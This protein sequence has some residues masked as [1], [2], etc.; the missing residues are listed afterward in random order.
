MTGFWTGRVK[1]LA[2]AAV[3]ASLVALRGEAPGM[4]WVVE[5]RVTE[6]LGKG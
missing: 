4:V 3:H 6:K 5:G 1:D 2:A